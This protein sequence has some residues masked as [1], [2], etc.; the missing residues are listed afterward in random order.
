M[1]SKSKFI[2][3]LLNLKFVFAVYAIIT[4]VI[5]FIQYHQGV[6]VFDGHNYTHY[7]NY[8]IFKNSYQ[9]LVSNQNPYQLWVNEHWDLFKYSPTFALLMYPFYQLPDVIGLLIWN[10][11]NTLILFFAFT[12]LKNL[13]SKTKSILLYFILPEMVI[14]L[15]NSQSNALIAGLLIAALN[16]MERKNF[17][18]ATL[19]ITLSVYIKIFGVVA[20]M[21]CLFY[22][23]R[24]KATASAI[25]WM[26][27][28]AV[29]PAIVIGFDQL[30]LDYKNWSIM[31]AADQDAS[32]GL[33]ILGWLKTWFHIDASKNMV[34]LIGAIALCIP[35]IRLKMYQ[36]YKFR[37]LMLANMLIWVVL[38]NHK[39]ESP[40]FIIAIAG[41]AL[42]YFHSNGSRFDLSLLLMAF[43]FTSLSPSDL[44][45]HFVR[46]NFFKPYVI[47]VI[48]MIIIW[49][50][51]N[52]DMFTMPETKAQ[53]LDIY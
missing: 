39:A 28:F 38:F 14:A 43:V 2:A 51:I 42:W 15:Q 16:F 9:H 36:Q 10:L 19:L 47:K 34:T 11:L 37:I 33:S 32:V 40:T 5:S 30:I 49:I 31:L 1:W 27:L 24:W 48:P 21:L 53:V 17:I 25:G 22:N 7:N 6:K 18:M 13:D 4:V 45:P 26:I 8:V 29:L 3:T 44:F 35:M 20:F 12:G 41:A 50:K 46:D 52:Y 23:E